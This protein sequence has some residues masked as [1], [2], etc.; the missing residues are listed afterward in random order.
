[1]V[2]W[3][4]IRTRRGK[5]RGY[6]CRLQNVGAENVRREREIRRSGAFKGLLLVCESLRSLD[7]SSFWDHSLQNLEMV[8]M[9]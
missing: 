1:M 4:P 5:G 3:G 9:W 2:G 8:V 6:N 7:I